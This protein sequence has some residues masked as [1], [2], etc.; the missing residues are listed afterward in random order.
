MCSIIGYFKLSENARVNK[1]F[2][3]HGLNVMRHRGPDAEAIRYF[4]GQKLCLG[5]QRLAI[6][7]VSTGANQPMLS[8]SGSLVFN[9]EIYNYVELKDKLKK[10]RI[11]FNTESDTEVLLKGL[12]KEGLQF[13]NSTNGMFAFAHYQFINQTLILGRDRFGVKPLYYLVENE[14]LYFASEIRALLRIKSTLERNEEYYH[15]FFVDTATDYNDLTHINGIHQVMPGHLLFV[16]DKE[17]KQKK[18]YFGRDFKIKKSFFSTDDKTVAFVEDLLTDA[19]RIRIRADVPASISLSGGLDSSILYVLAKEKLATSLKAFSLFDEAPELSEKKKI[20]RLVQSYGDSVKSFTYTTKHIT[21]DVKE[22]LEAVEFPI[23]DPSVVVYD[24]LYKNIHRAGYKMVIEGHGSDEL[25]G[26]YSYMVEEA[27][28]DYFRSNHFI[29]GL[30]LLKSNRTMNVYSNDQSIFRK[31]VYLLM[32]SKNKESLDSFEKIVEI[33]FYYKILPIVLRAFDRLS[34][35]NSL[36]S[37]APFMDYRVVETFKKLPKKYKVDTIGSKAILR[38]ILK[39]YG[40]DYIYLDKRKIGFGLK[41]EELLN[42]SKELKLFFKKNIQAFDIPELNDWKV[43]AQELINKKRITNE[44]ISLLWKVASVGYI[45]Q[46]L[47]T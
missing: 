32:K 1:S 39:K 41:T 29:K 7:D 33:S 20:M 3:K 27:I 23:W 31:L 19:L 38:L 2:M 13:L 22:S 9:G 37:R 14:V 18:W 26:G 47:F 46:Q 36:E 16:N 30:R 12:E 42:N 10:K 45:D 43:N 21:G 28:V 8:Q 4:D 11:K 40:K 35:K 5:G 24:Q 34:M 25:L 17:V 15:N 44:D 6:V